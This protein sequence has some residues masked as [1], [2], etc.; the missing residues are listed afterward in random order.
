MALNIFLVKLFISFIVAGFVVVLFTLLAEKYGS[1]IGGVITTLPSI[2]AL[3]LFFIGVTNS[4]ETVI[5]A[6]PASVLGLTAA[7]IFLI[8]YIK[9]SG[10]RTKKLES[11]SISIALSLF[12]W[13]MFDFSLFVFVPKELMPALLTFSLVLALMVYCLVF[14][15]EKKIVMVK[16]SKLSQVELFFRSVFGGGTVALTV[17]FAYI[18]GPI[19]GGFASMFPAVYLSTYVILEWKNGS[20]FIHALGRMTPIGALSSFVY[21]LF[22]YFSYPR[23]GIILGTIFSYLACLFVVASIFKITTKLTKI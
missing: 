6:I 8:V 15:E 21:V 2:S 22:V 9:S 1:R 18:L 3:S 16:R 23:L 11:I 12:I 17:I 19:W 4:V 20:R 10:L 13:F 5:R 14:R 7:I